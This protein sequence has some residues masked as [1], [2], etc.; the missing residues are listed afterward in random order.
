MQGN[1]VKDVTFWVS[2]IIWAFGL[3]HHNNFIFAH[4]DMPHLKCK[5]DVRS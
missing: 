4:V 3:E 1:G 2:C 5:S